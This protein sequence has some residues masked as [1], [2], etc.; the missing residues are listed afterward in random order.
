MT[1]GSVL[2]SVLLAL[3]RCYSTEYPRLN[4]T[5]TYVDSMRPHQSLASYVTRQLVPLFPNHV[6]ADGKLQTVPS[7]PQTNFS[8]CGVFAT[9]YAV[10]L[11]TGNFSLT[12]RKCGLIWS[13]V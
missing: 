2:I 11:T 10:E 3:S 12:L 9:A 4:D 7:M 6:G 5:V 1:V 8:E 13:N